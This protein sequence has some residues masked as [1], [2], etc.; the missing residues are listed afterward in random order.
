MAVHRHHLRTRRSPTMTS[1]LT[2]A[3]TWMPAP[4]HRR[5]FSGR[6]KTWLPRPCC[7]A[8]ARSPQPRRSDEYASS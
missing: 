5:F 1:T 2:K 7:C 8:A 3:R 6:P 4:T